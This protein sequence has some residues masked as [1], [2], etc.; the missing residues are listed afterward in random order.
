[1]VKHEQL[2]AGHARPAITRK[3]KRAAGLKELL[4]AVR[5]LWN[6]GRKRLWE[7]C[8]LFGYGADKQKHLAEL[9]VDFYTHNAH[10]A[11]DSDWVPHGLVE[12]MA[13]LGFKVF[14][15]A[16]LAGEVIK[17][18]GVTDGV[19]DAVQKIFPQR[20]HCSPTRVERL[21]DERVLSHRAHKM[22]PYADDALG[23]PFRARVYLTMRA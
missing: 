23:S 11:R 7:L 9:V 10:P 17:A 16:K 13:V 15:R 22:H 4:A 2:T 1:M 8:R 12:A 14:S 21:P 5:N 20:R 3:E 19:E 6:L 18:Q